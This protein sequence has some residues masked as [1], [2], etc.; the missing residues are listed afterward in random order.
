L[1]IFL[2]R[3]LRLSTEQYALRTHNTGATRLVQRCDDVLKK[4]EISIREWGHTI[5]E[6]L[7]WIGELVFVRIFE[8]WRT[9]LLKYRFTLFVLFRCP[10]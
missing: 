5:D 7:E 6:A 9:I 1:P 4:Y 2:L 8:L 3:L 10:V